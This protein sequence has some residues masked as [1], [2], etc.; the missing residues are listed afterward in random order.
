MKN[1]DSMIKLRNVSKM[2]PNKVQALK[3][4]SL[5]I[6]KGELVYLIGSSGSGKSSL[7]KLLYREEIADKGT[8]HIAEHD[9]RKKRNH[10]I[11]QLRRDIGVVFQDFRLMPDWTVYENIAYA[12]EVTECPKDEIKDR[13]LEVLDFVNLTYKVLDYP[14]NCSGGEQQRIAIARA[15]VNKP[16]VLLA[17][18]PTGNL[19]PVT[20]LEILR[21]F[22]RINQKGTTILMSTHDQKLAKTTPFR[23][24]ELKQ[25]QVIQDVHPETSGLSYNSVTKEYYVI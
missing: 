2:Y 16:K 20:T 15:L 10:H 7:M 3:N 14:K 25:G 24:I 19:D 6:K 9:V 18:E 1:G 5:D 4:V 21:L 17:D 11:H 8:I 13:V 12:L 23:V 22:Y